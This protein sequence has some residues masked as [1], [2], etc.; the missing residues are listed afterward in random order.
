MK[1]VSRKSLMERV[2]VAGGN[3][4]IWNGA[5]SKEGYGV[6]RCE[7]GQRTAPRLFWETF[8]GPILRGIP[9]P[10]PQ[11][12]F[13]RR[14]GVLQPRASPAAG[15]SYRNCAS[16]LQSGAFAYSGQCSHRE[17][18]R[19]RL[20]PVPHLPPGGVAKLAK[21]EFVARS[22]PRILELKERACQ[23]GENA[24]FDWQMPLVN[25]P[26]HAGESPEM[27]FPGPN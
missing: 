22:R 26:S 17:S 21:T 1:I 3:C 9:C 12:A 13:L 7:S 15:A 6:L 16:G 27:P 10:L 2:T 23:E 20:P 24:A 19:T 18:Q 25:L 14:Q 5:R 11:D 8:V 4:W